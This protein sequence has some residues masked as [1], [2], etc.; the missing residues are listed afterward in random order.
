NKCAVLA[1]QAARLLKDGSHSKRRTLLVPIISAKNH[2]NLS[3][4]DPIKGVYK[5]GDTI[6]TRVDTQGRHAPNYV[7]HCNGRHQAASGTLSGSVAPLSISVTPEMKGVCLL[8]VYTAHGHIEADVLLFVVEESC[9]HSVVPIGGA[10]RPGAEIAVQLDA[11]REGVALLS[12]IDDRLNW[13]SDKPRTWSDLLPSKFWSFQSPTDSTNHTANLINYVEVDTDIIAKCK[14]AG[15]AYYNEFRSCPETIVTMSSFTDTCLR[16]L[17]V[18]CVLTSQ[19]SPAVS[20]NCGKH[21]KCTT[22]VPSAGF[23]DRDPDRGQFGVFGMVMKT[24]MNDAAYLTERQPIQTRKLLP[25]VW[26]FEDYKIPANGRLRLNYELPD[27]IG[28][29]SLISSFWS[30]GDH[31]LCLAPEAFVDVRKDFFLQANV[32]ASA[33]LN[34][35]VAVEIIVSGD[36]VEEAT[37]LVI[38][39]LMDRSVCSDVG[40]NGE[41]GEAVF[42]RIELSPSTPIVTK[43][44]AMRFLS[45]GS[46]NVTFTLRKEEHYPGRYHCDGGEIMDA[47]QHT[48]L[49][50]K[51]AETEE[52]YRGLILTVDK[53]VI[54]SLSFEGFGGKTPIIDIIQVREYR[55]ASRPA[56]LMTEITTPLK[57]TDQI[58]TFSIE[59]SKFLPLP[60]VDFEDAQDVGGRRKRSAQKQSSLSSAFLTDVLQQLSLH[61]FKQEQLRAVPTTPISALESLDNA[62]SSS[63]SDMLRFSNCDDRSQEYCGFANEGKP[64]SNI[65]YSVFLTSMSVSLLC[66]AS[67]DPQFVCGALEFLHSR[68]GPTNEKILKMDQELNDAM[69]FKTHTD[70]LYFT[71][72]MLRQAVEDCRMYACLA[73]GTAKHDWKPLYQ[74]FYDYNDRNDLDGRTVAALATFSTPATKKR[75][76]GQ[77]SMDIQ[78]GD[79]APFWSARTPDSVDGGIQ[80]TGRTKAGDVLINSLALIAFID[81]Q[82]EVPMNFDLLADWIDEQ[83]GVDELYGNVVD[84]FFAS[85]AISTYRLRKGLTEAEENSI[86]VEIKCAGCPPM[87]V[88]VTDSAPLFYI[89]TN[90]RNLTILTTGRGKARAGVRILSAKKQR[91][92][93]GNVNA[94]PFPVEITVDQTNSRDGKRLTTLTQVVCIKP[95]HPRVK[96]VEI[97]HGIFTGYT[98]Q[99]HLLAVVDNSSSHWNSSLVVP[100]VERPA[101]ISTYAVH[102]VLSGLMKG[103]Q[104]CYQLGL[105]EPTVAYEPG[106]LA[107]IAI[108]VRDATN[109]VIGESIVLHPD[110]RGRFKRSINLVMPDRQQVVVYDYVPRRRGTT[111]GFSSLPFLETLRRSRR[112]SLSDPIDAVCFPGGHCT[113]AERSCNVDCSSCGADESKFVK[114]DVCEH[115]AFAATVE[116]TSISNTQLDGSDFRLLELQVLH[117]SSRELGRP[118]NMTAWLRPCAFSCTPKVAV[119][120]STFIFI[121]ES[122]A[123][124]PDETGRLNYVLRDWDRFIK[125]D[126]K[127]SSVLTAVVVNKC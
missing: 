96:Y 92:R 14:S 28:R 32:P 125:A 105:A 48:V 121:G 85:R 74:L 43:T 99:S 76:R 100:K 46:H 102:F 101:F 65:S 124:V 116:I 13:I 9:K 12:A 36:F 49:V 25:H 93:R 22:P 2:L 53:P 71:S 5:A 123:V 89:P 15:D 64:T 58:S 29:W 75:M 27:T 67:A 23:A 55:E 35:T 90:V 70:R 95:T 33:Y 73:A 61:I 72:Y 126:E 63:T 115:G 40:I 56:T 6:A 1:I 42:S 52:H 98:T 17:N 44:V 110:A 41:K 122:A 120:G 21:G 24:T 81:N 30:K 108:S 51:R 97:K 45:I 47:V 82:R 19:R 66:K 62:I 18:P 57:T 80:K 68:I 109:G 106:Q 69:Q 104:S 59:I 113:C 112:S 16:Y 127:C 3:W 117:W 50:Q 8:A 83:R 119:D 34:E 31:D 4:I 20:Y 88:N 78:S 91:Q 39:Q 60:Q 77:L 37:T 26:I 87:L 86:H 114:Q 107:P 10:T 11:A 118:V 38:C 7:V 79:I 54:D 103:N 84:T 94:I 111:T